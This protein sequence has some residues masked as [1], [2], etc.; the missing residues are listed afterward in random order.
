MPPLSPYAFISMITPRHIFAIYALM[1]RHFDYAA[2]ISYFRCSFSTGC[3]SPFLFSP[4]ATPYGVYA[5]TPTLCHCDHAN[6][7]LIERALVD[8]CRHTRQSFDAYAIIA[9]AAPALLIYGDA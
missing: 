4:R 1:P 3:L 9:R 2:A 8:C 7:T 6:I 5:E